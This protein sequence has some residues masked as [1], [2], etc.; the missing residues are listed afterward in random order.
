VP[1][2][3]TLTTPLWNFSPKETSGVIV[4]MANL[5]TTTSA[6]WML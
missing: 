4:A 2:I 5:P 3:A 6:L 1:T